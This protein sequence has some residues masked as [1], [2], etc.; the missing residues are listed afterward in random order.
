MQQ[1][2]LQVLKNFKPNDW[3]NPLYWPVEEESC[4]Y[5]PIFYNWEILLILCGRNVRFQIPFKSKWHNPY[6]VE[7][8]N[9]K[10][11]PGSREKTIRQYKEY[12]LNKPELFRLIPI[13]LKDKM[14]GCWCKPNK[15]HGD[16]LVELA[17]NKSYGN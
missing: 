7:K 5:F 2:L 16:V 11:V 10:E 4:N 13:E 14:L 1:N 15:C 8:T 12:I 17:D 3:V 6:T 9:G